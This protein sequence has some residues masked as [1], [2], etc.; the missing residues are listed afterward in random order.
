MP[1]PTK[2][3]VAAL[4]EM[5]GKRESVIRY[6]EAFDANDA[7]DIVENNEV[8]AGYSCIIVAVFPGHHTHATTYETSRS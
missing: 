4:R 6:V 2:F 1:N 7:G 5:D 3:T 8:D